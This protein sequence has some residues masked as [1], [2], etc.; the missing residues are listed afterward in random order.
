MRHS[1][2]T[3]SLEDRDTYGKAFLQ[4]LNLWRV[5]DSVRQFV[6][7]GRFAEVAARLLGV[8]AV[9]LYHDQ[10]LFKEA[11]GGRTP[12]H[13]DQFYWPFDSDQT[14]TLWMPLIDITADIGSMTFASGS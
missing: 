8:K 3:R 11:G 2:E 7:A 9:R 14:V 6:F 13:Q 10:A 12:C 1:R 4:L 5:D